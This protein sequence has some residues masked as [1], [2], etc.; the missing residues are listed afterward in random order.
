MNHLE[1]HL[2]LL[3]H[4]FFNR[5]PAAATGKGVEGNHSLHWEV[6]VLAS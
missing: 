6:T 4:G 5:R 2:R 1:Q 3:Q